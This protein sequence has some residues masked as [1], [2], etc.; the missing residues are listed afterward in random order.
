MS[1]PDQ[2]KLAMLSGHA[3]YCV[4]RR[5]GREEAVAGLREITK[6]PDLLARCAGNL[7][8][9][10]DT[11]LGEWPRRR[12]AARFLVA[13]GADREQIARWAE[14]GRET[15]TRNH[16]SKIWHEELGALL[17]EVLPDEQ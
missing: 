13:A 9:T 4:M 1:T 11:E 14:A 16:P 15:A 5:L 3:Q 6:R 2:L 7:I 17:A 12:D 8:G 10:T